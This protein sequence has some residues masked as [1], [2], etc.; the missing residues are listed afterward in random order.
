MNINS[1][2]VT[3][4]QRELVLAHNDT[5]RDRIKASLN[6]LIKVLSNKI[7]DTIVE[8]ILF[9]SYTRNTILPREFDPESDI[10]LMVVFDKKNYDYNAGT[11]RK[12]IH[13]VVSAAYPNSISQK[14]FPVVKLQLN[15][16]MFDIVPAYWGRD[17]LGGRVCYIP[18]KNDGWRVTTPNDINKD[19][20]DKNSSY[21]DNVIRNVIRLC[22]HWNAGA[23]YPFES[24]LMEKKIIDLVYWGNENTYER[25][26]KTLNSIAGDRK[27]VRTA[28]NQIEKYKGDWFTQ[29]DHQQ[30]FAWLQ[31]LLPRLR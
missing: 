13:D 5:E 4:A 28:L 24:Y 10:D 17:F 3:F 1:K 15:H 25:F 6:Q 22:K 23:D 29:G 14:D 7:G 2:L 30:Q 26:L 18:D 31:K 11:Y 9:G 16:T 20:S 12:W 27:D 19:L 8:F 21:G